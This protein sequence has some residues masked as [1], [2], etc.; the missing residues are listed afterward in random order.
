VYYVEGLYFPGRSV[1]AQKIKS[2]FSAHPENLDADFQSVQVI[3]RNILLRVEI[4]KILERVQL[5][6]EYVPSNLLGSLWMLTFDIYS[7]STY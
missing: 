3:G 6:G 2:Q 5:S 1:R 4:Q 7:T